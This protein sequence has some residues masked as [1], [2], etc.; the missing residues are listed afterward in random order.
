MTSFNPQNSPASKGPSSFNR[1]DTEPTASPRLAAV[2]L[3]QRGRSRICGLARWLRA[4]R[5][6]PCPYPE[7][8]WAH[9]RCQG[10]PHCRERGAAGIR[11]RS[12]AQGSS[13]LASAQPQMSPLPGKP[14]SSSTH[15]GNDST[16]LLRVSWGSLEGGMMLKKQWAQGPAST[17][18]QELCSASAC[19]E[20]VVQLQTGGTD[21]RP[22]SMDLTK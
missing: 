12:P 22:E 18:R 5:A 10:G 20:F 19:R 1:G 11:L 15:W 3:L 7:H 4:L 17:W 14:A 8:G 9:G 16:R 13:P 6:I 21:E 2:A